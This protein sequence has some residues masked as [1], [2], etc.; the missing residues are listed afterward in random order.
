MTYNIWKTENFKTISLSL[1]SSSKALGLLYSIHGIH[2]S[3]ATA[4][5]FVRPVQH[6][7]DSLAYF[8]DDE[9][10]FFEE[11]FSVFKLIGDVSVH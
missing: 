10:D 6:L 7:F 4:R 11:D 9:I 3:P 2:E 8:L 1:S 5:Q